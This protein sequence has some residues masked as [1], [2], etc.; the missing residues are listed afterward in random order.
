MVS[1]LRLHSWWGLTSLCIHVAASVLC[2]RDFSISLS[3]CLLLFFSFSSSSSASH[4]S[5]FSYCGGLVTLGLKCAGAKPGD[6]LNDRHTDIL[7]R[8]FSL[9]SQADLLNL[10]Q[11]ETLYLSIQWRYSFPNATPSKSVES[12]WPFP[13]GPLDRLKWP[14]SDP[15]PL[16]RR[17]AHQL[18]KKHIV[19]L[20]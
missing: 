14:S 11:V 10:G 3:S 19:Q 2:F 18:I 15:A 9:L 7:R 20:V 17:K 5:S 6:N 12:W 8:L 1:L 4:S 13:I 16:L